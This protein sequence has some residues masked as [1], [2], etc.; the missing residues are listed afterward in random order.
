M[1]GAFRNMFLE[2]DKMPVCAPSF[3]ENGAPSHAS[4]GC[5]RTDLFFK[6]TRDVT[7]NTQ[8]EHWLD[9]A[10]NECP[11]DTMRI[12]FHG[13]DCRGGKGDRAPF[14][15]AF[16]RIANK[17][18][19]WFLANVHHVPE[20][21][22]WLDLI[23]LIPMLHDVAHKAHIVTLLADQLRADEASVSASKGDSVSLL[24]KWMPSEKSKWAKATN[25]IPLVCRELFPSSTFPEKQYR[26]CLTR[27]RTHIDVTE[28]RMCR[29]QEWA[30]IPFSKVPSV[31]M[32]RLREAFEKHA[33]EEFNVWL[34]SVAKGT[35]KVNASQVYPHDLVRKYLG[36]RTEP[37]AVIE[38]Q[39]KAIVKQTASLGLFKDSIVVADVSG[40]MHGTPMEVSI[41]LGILIA[42]LTAPP[43]DGLLI[44]FS[45][46]PTFFTLAPGLRL[47]DAVEQVENMLWGA[48]TDLQKVF[49][50]ILERALT[51]D[52]KADSM[53]KR[54]YILSD[55][56]FDC[57]CNSRGN[58]TNFDAI[59][60]KY[61]T[62]GYVMPQ[63]VF[64]NLRSDCKKDV[65]VQHDTRGVALLSG[66]SPAILKSLMTG[67]E[68]S[69][70]VIMRAAIDDARYTA[71]AAPLTIDPLSP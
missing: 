3:T 30:A 31:A 22:R 15:V 48:N 8:F 35:S 63:I 67:V 17:H 47:Y 54:L 42:S 50:L 38:E 11:L 12:L 44:T 64:W 29:N 20:Y 56:Q 71:I 66:Y 2:I 32:S 59:R 6:L 60:A 69:P 51:L 58:P 9:A 26:Q 46:S 33:P 45:E 4:S 53:P 36:A 34:E 27:L 25:L 24:A 23:E 61:A 57:A 14:L 7:K 68:V 13:R 28:Q 41:A 40:S 16:A 39:W 21:G 5:A 65:P 52:V 37:C 10:W 70:W 1:A 43:F 55:M 18:P 19:E 49:S 62:A